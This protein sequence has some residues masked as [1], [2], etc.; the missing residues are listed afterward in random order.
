M[1]NIKEYLNESL[2]RKQA[3]VDIKT[4]IERQLQEWGIKHYNINPDMTID[5]TNDEFVAIYNWNES[6]LPDYIQFNEVDGCFL[7]KES[8]LKT[9]RGC[10]RIVKG[11]F[12]CNFN[13]ELENLEGGPQ[14][15]GHYFVYNCKNIESLKGGPKKVYGQ[16]RKHEGFVIH[17]CPKLQNF[18]L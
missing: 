9:L 8:K 14:E 17:S 6:K 13:H 18:D 2:I 12:Y 16:S 15:T 4:K 1:K 3:S 7:I 5:V 10:P 11:N